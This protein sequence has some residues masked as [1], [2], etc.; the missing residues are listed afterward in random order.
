MRRQ[1]LFYVALTDSGRPRRR[2][3]LIVFYRSVKTAQ[4]YSPGHKIEAWCGPDP[5]EDEIERAAIEVT[6]EAV[7]NAA[8]Q[9]RE[10]NAKKKLAQKNVKRSEKEPN[11]RARFRHKGPR[12]F[13]EG[14]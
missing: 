10:A 11:A 2:N 8:Q 9:I 5:S 12:N 3:G 6:P 13:G 1:G 7:R 14:D 4:R